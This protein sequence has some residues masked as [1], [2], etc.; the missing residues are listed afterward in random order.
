[1][2]LHNFLIS[3]FSWSVAVPAAM[4]CF[5][6][7]KNQFRFRGRKMLLFGLLFLIIL[8]AVVSFIEAKLSLGYNAM[9][10]FIAI[11]TFAAYHKSLTV[12][13]EKALS[14]YAL[15]F[16]FMAFISN[17]ANGFDAILHPDSTLNNFSLEAAVFQAILAVIVSALFYYPMRKYGSLLIDRFSIPRVWYITLPVSAI[18]LTCNLMLAPRKYETLYVNLIFLVFWTALALLFVLLLLLCVLFYFIVSGIMEA[19]RTQ[20]R[21]RILE[22]Q[23]R[24]YL[25]QQ[26]HIEETARI[27]HDFRHTLG[28]L[29]ELVT[30]GDLTA[31]RAYLDDYLA[32]QPKKDTTNFCEDT[33]VNALLNYYMH[34]ARN[35][36]ITLDWEISL[37]KNPSVT[38]IDLCGILGNILDNAILACE[39]LSDTRLFIELTVRYDDTGIYIVATNPFDG[40]V[41]KR[42]GQYLSTRR[43]GTGTGLKS[44]TST[45]EKYGGTARFSHNNSEFFSDVIL[46]KNNK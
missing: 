18:F 20:E 30:K 29:D 19:A 17:C 40:N 35:A 46:P 7:M 43:H 32:T 37:P 45:A 14:I 4:L 16:T 27:R 31:I 41:R 13:I 26:R 9:L 12:P 5:A 3:F 34:R 2:N 15:V 28:T 38:N 33:A 24:T 1:M 44:I 11:V 39:G 10:P 8:L 22:M 42:D 25:S 36:G 23:E 6:P 21:N